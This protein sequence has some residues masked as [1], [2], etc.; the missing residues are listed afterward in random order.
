MK[1]KDFNEI[2]KKCFGKEKD[3]KYH[4][5]AM[6]IIYSIF[7]LIVVLMIRLGGSNVDNE[8]ND[9]TNQNNNIINSNPSPQP[10]TEPKEDE[11]E[12]DSN[13]SGSDINYSYSYTITYN[14]ENEVYLGK[15]LDDK[16][17]FTLI[18]NGITKDYA[19]LS[20]NYLILENNIYQI[21]ENPSN[22]F[23]YCDVEKL[24]VLTENEISTQ[25]ENIIKYNITNKILA[26]SYK[27]DITVDNEQTNLITFNI[28]NN[29]LK[30]VDLDFS[31][32]ISAVEGS[33]STLTIH[34]EFV[35]IGTTE[36]FEIKVS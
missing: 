23:K 3:E 6:L 10:S 19:I 26:N 29:S 5:V 16:E 33:Q 15:K 32:Y 18:K 28:L 25:N 35:D 20:D 13:I 2:L 36:D 8:V 22:F 12:V 1:N 17:K 4:A 24:L 34:M 7:L 14:G 30:S 9:N 31:N 21:T 27:D 11:E